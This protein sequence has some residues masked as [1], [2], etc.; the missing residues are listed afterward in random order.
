[1]LNPPFL[2]DEW[3][4]LVLTSRFATFVAFSAHKKTKGPRSAN[5]MAIPWRQ[6]TDL[7]F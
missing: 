5:R 6:E 3:I 1:M 2:D 7:G 4:A